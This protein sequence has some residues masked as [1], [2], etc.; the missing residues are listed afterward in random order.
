MN[1]D[2]PSKTVNQNGTEPVAER[3][4][5]PIW[6]ILVCG[7]LIY[8]GSVFMANNAGGFAEVVYNPYHSPEEVDAANPQDPG[9]KMRAEGR[10]VFQ[11]TCALCHQLTGLG[12]EG[13]YPP[14]AGSEWVLAPGGNRIVRIVLRGL[15]GPITV[16]GQQFNGAMPPFGDNFNDDQIAAVL[17]YIRSQSDWGNKAGPIAPALVKTARAEKHPAPMSSTELLSIPPQ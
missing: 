6:Q 7:L 4:N 13:T 5:V 17:T 8:W 12:K 15:S 2:A 9:A 11:N 10:K 1:P 14:L 3:W 16:K